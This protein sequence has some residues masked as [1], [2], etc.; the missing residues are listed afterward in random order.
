MITKK[1][2]PFH[3]VKSG[4]T[5]RTISQKYDIDSTKI[6]LDNSLSPKQIKEGIFIILKKD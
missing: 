4:E 1:T 5:L 6:L 3:Q 2:F